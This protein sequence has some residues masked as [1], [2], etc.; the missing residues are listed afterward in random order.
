M[1]DVF[2][3]PDSP[4]PPP[5][6]NSYRTTF[7]R[8]LGTSQRVLVCAAYDVESGLELR[9]FYSDVTDDSG[10]MRSQLFRG[11]DCD[12]HCAETA[13]RW[14]IALLEKGFVEQ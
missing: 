12:E 8:V 10:L 9:L 2:R 6:K 14:R 13:D 7:F 5:P 11:V 1:A 4:P 3:F